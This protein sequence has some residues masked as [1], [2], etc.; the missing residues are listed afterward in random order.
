MCLIP[1]V[2]TLSTALKEEVHIADGRWIPDPITL[3]NFFR[4]LRAGFFRAFLISMLV[5]VSVTGLQALTSSLAAYAFS[6]LHFKGRDRIFLAYLGTMMIPPVVTMIPTFLLIREL[7]ILDS[8]VGLILP[9][10]FSSYG[11]FFLRQYFLTI[12]RE[13]EEA[14]LIDGASRLTIFFQIILPLS[15]PALVTI[16]IFVFISTWNDFMW[17][18]IIVYSNELMTLPLLLAKFKGQYVSNTATV[19]AGSLITV[20]PVVVFLILGQKSLLRGIVMSGL[21]G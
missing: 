19:M 18:L 17:P 9:C 4:A 12:P 3:D 21:K 2:W 14:A 1:F 13:L 11:T 6:R 20:I 5:A 16:L 7:G 15:K 8:L 10:I